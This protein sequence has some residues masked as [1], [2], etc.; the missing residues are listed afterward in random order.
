MKRSRQLREHTRPVEEGHRERLLGSYGTVRRFLP[1]LLD[2]LKF[3]ATDAG[4]QVLDALTALKPIEHKHALEPDDV[5]MQIVSRSWRRLAKPELARSTDTRTPSAHWRRC[6]RV[7]TVATCS[8]VALTGVGSEFERK[9]GSGGGRVGW[10]RLEGP[11]GGSVVQRVRPSSY[12]G[13]HRPSQRRIMFDSLASMKRA[14]GAGS[15]VLEE[16]RPELRN[17]RLVPRQSR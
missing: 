7:F 3:Q 12:D 10:R 1:L 2:T 13:F 4:A 9:T 8:S 17:V 5:A 11:V 6:A 16:S 14:R 15:R